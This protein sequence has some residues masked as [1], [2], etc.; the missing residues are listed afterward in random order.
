MDTQ[1]AAALHCSIDLIHNR[2]ERGLLPVDLTP[3]LLASLTAQEQAWA[4]A[5]TVAQT[6]TATGKSESTIIRLIRLRVVQPISHPLGGRERVPTAALDTIRTWASRHTSVPRPP[7]Q[8]LRPDITPVG[9]LRIADIAA[10]AG[11]TENVVRQ[12][13]IQA[14]ITMRRDTARRWLVAQA[15]VEQAE[16][17]GA[18]ARVG[19]AR[20]TRTPSRVPSRGP[21]PPTYAAIA[22][23][24]GY[25][26]QHITAMVKR[27]VLA[28][29]LDAV[30]R[31]RLTAR[32][33]QTHAAGAESACES[34]GQ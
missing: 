2:Q 17:R 10:W 1:L 25:T 6:A 27:G 19:Y 26:R 14:N 18:F 32:S 12:V 5:L 3:E 11:C 20:L 13:C 22:R 16:S 28:W 24:F 4:Q 34:E 9:W 15:S 7:L 30:G 31:A 23:E 33:Q 29:P 21:K 8:R